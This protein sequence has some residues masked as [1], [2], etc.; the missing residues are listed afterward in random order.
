MYSIPMENW[1]TCWM[2]YGACGTVA[3]KTQKR[4]FDAS[5]W[6]MLNVP[7]LAANQTILFVLTDY[8]SCFIP[9]NKQK[10]T[11]ICLNTGVLITEIPS[12]ISFHCPCNVNMYTM[13][14]LFSIFCQNQH[15]ECWTEILI[16]TQESATSPLVLLEALLC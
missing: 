1:F 6:E 4:L 16:I 7:K 11:Q 5:A 10:F 15:L 13:F 12:L 3:E 14:C 9:T 8:S 2:P